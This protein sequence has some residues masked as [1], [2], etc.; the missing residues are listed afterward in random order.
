MRTLLFAAA[1]LIIA[2]ACESTT[3]KSTLT[4]P[5][6]D[7]KGNTPSLFAPGLVSTQHSQRDLAIAPDSSE[8]FYTQ[9][10]PNSVYSALVRWYRDEAGQWQGPQ[11]A[12]FS[13]RWRDLEPAYSPDG[14][15]LYFASNRPVAGDSAKDFDLWRV[16]KTTQGWGEPENLGATVNGPGNEF[17]PS[18]AAN[19]NLYFTAQREDAVGLEDIYRSTYADGAWAPA[20]PLDTGVNS[21]GYEF[22]AYVAPDESYL[23]FSGYRRPDGFGG[24]DLYV[25]LR[26]EGGVF[27]PARNL[28]AEINTPGLDYCP[29]V[30]QHTLYY[31]STRSLLATSPDSALNWATLNEVLD[32]PE[33]GNSSLFRIRWSPAL[34]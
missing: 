34:E 18:I 27:G 26:G 14:Q 25:S 6:L 7:A 1:T 5:G 8:L 4:L 16:P 22:N 19:G 12:P 15:W 11:I 10:A 3:D 32:G 17:Y 33:N 31:T 13:G 23:L 30:W 29:F 9:V 21:A 24:G 2:V 20:V 28:G